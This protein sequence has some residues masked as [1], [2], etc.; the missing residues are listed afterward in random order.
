MLVDNLGQADIFIGFLDFEGGGASWLLTTYSRLTSFFRGNLVRI[1]L[2]CLL[3]QSVV[4]KHD[5]IL[6][7]RLRIVN[8]TNFNVLCVV[9][10]INLSFRVRLYHRII[11]KFGER[12]RLS[13]FFNLLWQF[14][15]V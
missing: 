10:P 12:A 6:H 13:Q 8:D 5:F 14:W 11:S 4:V 9:F 3:F 15:L 7:L 1:R 2:F